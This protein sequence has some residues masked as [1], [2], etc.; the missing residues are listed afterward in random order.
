MELQKI[1]TK[2]LLQMYANAA[3]TCGSYGHWKR[4]Q[5]KKLKEKYA[6]ELNNRG[7]KVPKNEHEDL[8]KFFIPNV[9]IPRG[10]FN[11][12]GSY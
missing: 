8:D 10:H 3:V 6:I 4:S 12:I 7:I 1:E 2:D 11:G 5:N 9:K